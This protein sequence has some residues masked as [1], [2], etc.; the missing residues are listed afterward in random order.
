MEAVT[1]AVEAAAF[2]VVEADSTAAEVASMEVAAGSMVVVEDSAQAGAFT[3]GVQ[4]DSTQ[5]AP[6]AAELRGR[7]AAARARIVAVPTVLLTSVV[8]HLPV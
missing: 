7:I 8:V 5:A 2:T 6:I 3:V 1:A 4:A